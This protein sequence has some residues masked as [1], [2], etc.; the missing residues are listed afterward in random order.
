MT[1]WKFAL[2]WTSRE[3][4]L[5]SPKVHIFCKKVFTFYETD[6]CRVTEL[7]NSKEIIVNKLELK[8]WLMNCDITFPKQQVR[9]MRCLA[10]AWNKISIIV[11]FGFDMTSC[12]IGPVSTPTSF[13]VQENLFIHS[14]FWGESPISVFTKCELTSNWMYAWRTPQ[15]SGLMLPGAWDAQLI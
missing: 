13:A 9:V 6:S 15:G 8:F 3:Q 7:W 5:T 2:W 14:C 1:S 4:L 10:R 12:E 11:K